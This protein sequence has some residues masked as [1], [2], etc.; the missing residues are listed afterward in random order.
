LPSPGFA[1]GPCLVKDTQ[2]LNFYYDDKFKLGKSVLEVNENLPDFLIDKLNTLIDISDKTIGILGMTFKGEIDDFRQSL[3]FRLKHILENRVKK[4]FC[5]DTKLQEPY[6]VNTEELIQN[7]DIIIIA[8]PHHE[9]KTIL[10]D[11]I[12]IDI[13]R[14]TKNKSLI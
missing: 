11:K 7:S 4:V 14:I 9:Y 1:A 5:S 12:I 13:W 6:F 2:Q 8:T 3:S 10:T